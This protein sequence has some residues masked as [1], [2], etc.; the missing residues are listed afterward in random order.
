MGERVKF[1]SNG[2]TCDGY[3]ALP[4]KGNGAAVI[5]IQEWW[6]LVGHITD[7]ADRF[8]EEGFVA[9]APDLYHGVIAKE[10]DHAMKMLMGLAMD[11]AAL[12]IDGS[13]KYLNG[14]AEVTHKGI[15]VVGFCM[16]GSLALWSATI[17]KDISATVAFYPGM[18]WARM[19]PEWSNYAGK[20]AAIHCSESDGT[21]AAPGIQEALAGI[22]AGGGEAE[23]FDYPGT[24]HAFFNNERTEV[25]NPEAADIAWKRVISF[26]SSSLL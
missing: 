19:A 26:F 21:S 1:P 2:G 3:L 13:A 9:L 22:R 17:S 23:A 10:P 11:K 12:D 14:R 8:A 24:Q 25:Y 5:V 15:G 4:K 6:G 18:P 20:R 7:V 16:G